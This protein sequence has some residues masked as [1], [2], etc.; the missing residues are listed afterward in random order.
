MLSNSFVRIGRQV[1]LAEDRRLDRGFGEPLRQ[2]LLG[3]TRPSAD[4]TS[5]GG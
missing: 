2:L 3:R 5:A 4:G 1:V